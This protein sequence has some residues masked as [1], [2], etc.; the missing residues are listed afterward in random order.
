VPRES[1]EPLSEGE[2]GERE[3]GG[4]GWGVRRGGRVVVVGRGEGADGED[5]RGIVDGEVKGEI[6]V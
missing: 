5:E 3:F 6:W 4:P 2:G 1:E